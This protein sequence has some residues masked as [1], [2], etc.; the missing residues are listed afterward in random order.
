MLR[1]YENIPLTEQAM[2]DLRNDLRKKNQ[3]RDIDDDDYMEDDDIESENYNQQQYEMSPTE[4]SHSIILNSI[5][6]S[7]SATTTTTTHTSITITSTNT[8]SINIVTNKTVITVPAIPM[9]TPSSTIDYQ[10]KENAENKA[11]NTDYTIISSSSSS[12]PRLVSMFILFTI[13]ILF[14]V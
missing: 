2:Y 12:P 14:I 9:I 3:Y 6:S 13:L 5:T 8:L 7:T 11:S 1:S 4:V 10:Q